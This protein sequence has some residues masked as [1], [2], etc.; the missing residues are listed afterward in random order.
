MDHFIIEEKLKFWKFKKLLI[1]KSQNIWA[2]LG[3]LPI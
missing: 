2:Y 3:L 1:N